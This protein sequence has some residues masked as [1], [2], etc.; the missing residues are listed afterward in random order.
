MFIKYR[1]N[2][3]RAI[4]FCSNNAVYPLETRHCVVGQ[5]KGQSKKAKVTELIDGLDK[6]FKYFLHFLNIILTVLFGQHTKS[7]IFLKLT[8]DREK[9]TRCIFARQ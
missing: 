8:Y 6:V 3:Y 4:I 1:F 7:G 5:K 9:K 2:Q